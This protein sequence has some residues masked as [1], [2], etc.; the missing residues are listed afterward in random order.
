MSVIDPYGPVRVIDGDRRTN[1]SAESAALATNGREIT[2]HP[3][4]EVLVGR[5]WLAMDEFVAG[6]L[7]RAN[8]SVEP[9]R[10]PGEHRTIL[11]VAHLFADDLA[12]TKRP[13]DP[14]QFIEA[15]MGDGSDA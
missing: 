7:R 4:N 14:V 9:M 11:R 3:A 12:R 8:K 10:S 5:E 1:D 13:F 2:G 15:V 6:V